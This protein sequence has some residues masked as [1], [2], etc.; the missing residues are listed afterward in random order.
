MLWKTC[1]SRWLTRLKKLASSLMFSQFTALLVTCQP[2]TAPYFPSGRTITS[3][4]YRRRYAYGSNRNLIPQAKTQIRIDGS[5]SSSLLRVAWGQ[6][7]HHGLAR[8]H[9][10][11]TYE[12]MQRKSTIGSF[13]AK[14]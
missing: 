14:G 8:Q 1:L 11:G 4:V 6:H 12:D 13:P 2:R 7:W 3:M 10:R 5:I 9:S